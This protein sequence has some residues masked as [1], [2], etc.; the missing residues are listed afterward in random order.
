[1]YKIRALKYVKETTAKL[2]H[3]L[4]RSDVHVLKG[5]E[6]TAHIVKIEIKK[7]QE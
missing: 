3:L 6:S 4:Y 2:K 7:N 5:T 1:M